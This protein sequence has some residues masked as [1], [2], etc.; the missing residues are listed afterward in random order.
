MK[1]RIH[2]VAQ[3]GVPECRVEWT[4]NIGEIGQ[5]DSEEDKGSAAFGDRRSVHPHPS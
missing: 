2:P 3:A 1:Y 5:R 4:E